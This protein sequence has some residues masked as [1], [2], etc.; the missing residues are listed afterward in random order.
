MITLLLIMLLGVIIG[1]LFREK[2]FT[3]IISKAIFP[4]VLILLLFMGIT[5]GLNPLIINNILTLGYEAF[6]ITMG[7]LLGTIICS[8]LLWKFIIKDKI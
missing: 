7:A 1:R 3:T 8:V 6:V 4:I 5:I 2:K